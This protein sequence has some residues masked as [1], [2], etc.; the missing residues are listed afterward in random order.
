PDPL[1]LAQS[2][3]RVYVDAVVQGMPTLA[4]AL[5]DGARERLDAP[6][7]P[8]LKL[9]RGET[10]RALMRGAA[11]WQSDVVTALYSALGEAS[12][13]PVA[14]GATVTPGPAPSALNL[15][16]SLVDEDT[17]EREILS[18]RLDLAIMDAA[19]SEFSDLR[20]RLTQLENHREPQADDVIRASVLARAAVRCWHRAGFTL[21]AWRDLQWVLHQGLAERA[22]EGYHE[23]NRWLLGQGV[24]KEVDLRPFIRVGVSAAGAT[25]PSAAPVSISL[26]R[27]QAEALS[28]ALQGLSGTAPLAASGDAARAG[29]RAT[30]SAPDASAR[31]AHHP[32]AVLPMPMHGPDAAGEALQRLSR[33]AGPHFDHTV[34]MTQPMSPGLER[35]LRHA[36]G[37]DPTLFED[38][39]LTL[40]VLFNDLQQRKQQLKQVAGTP[41]ERATIEI[42]AL[43]FQSLL[44]EDRIPPAVRVWLARLQMPVLRVAVTEPDFFATLDHPARQLIDRVGGVVMGIGSGEEDVAAELE[45]EVK[46]IVQVVEAYPDTGGRVFQTVLTEFEAFLKQYLSSRNEATRDAVS[47]AQQVEQRE[48]LAIQ[49]TIELRR[50][51]NEVPVQEGVRQFLFRVWADVLAITSMAHGAQSDQ[52]REMKRTA[53]DL[54]WSA[55][56]KVTREERAHVISRAPALLRTL[57]DGMA[58]AG[59]EPDR[60]DA[61]IRS[62]NTA[63]AAAFNAKAAV[64]PTQ[65]FAELMEQLESLEEMLPDLAEEEIDES[66]VR[67]L[68]GSASAQVE[69]VAQTDDEPSAAMLSWARELQVGTWYQLQHGSDDVHTV[70]LAW[71]GQRKQLS[72]FVNAGGRCVLF[73]LRPLAAYL[74]SGRLQPAQDESLTV[75]ATRNALAQLDA[76][77]GQLLN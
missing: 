4:E 17:I 65:R 46:R 2:A 72:M 51:L 61:E 34:A 48:T 68:S 27:Q 59:I 1:R 22:V 14:P 54:I 21:E 55:S 15:T 47:V 73:Q 52:I 20:A 33:L 16:L 12:R 30:A 7:E 8:P 6:A 56:A 75:R 3:R 18:S 57:R 43:M 63:L 29:G 66:V 41:E 42:V 38:T 32:T 37:A 26:S 11:A 44:A 39:A 13:A 28:S 53:A 5:L 10:L 70:Q 62:L 71:Q 69:M 49:Y 9:A 67:D 40:P 25:A 64:I 74:Q 50:M 31:H 36:G 58:A 76:E 24:L 45:K 35:A 19:G 23:A 60:Q 77:P